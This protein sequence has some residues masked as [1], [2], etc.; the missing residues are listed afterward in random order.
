MGFPQPGAATGVNP[1]AGDLGG[2]TVAPTVV[3]THLSTAL[4]IAQ[5]G[6]A[7]TTAA[8]ALAALGG[9]AVAGDLGGTSAAPTVTGTHLGAALPVNQ[10]G[11]GQ[12]TAAAALAA[13]GGTTPNVTVTTQA[14]TTYTFVLADAD[15]VVEATAASAATFTLPLNASVAY[16]VG[17]ILTAVQGGAGKVSFAAGGTTM[18]SP[19][20]L[21]GTRAQWSTISALKIATDSWVLSGDL[22]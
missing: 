9:T 18:T 5:G 7:S 16:P 21:V 8:A 19:G 1:P 6:T 11:T 3:A 15:T 14:G 17:T 2:T 10:G 4:P 13:L 20:S 12:T 22:A